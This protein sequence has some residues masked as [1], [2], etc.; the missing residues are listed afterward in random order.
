MVLI[1]RAH[2]FHAGRI[3]MHALYRRRSQL[4]DRL[5]EDLVEMSL[6]PYL[7]LRK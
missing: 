5:L 3:Y 6:S 7:R 2:A 1:R 4:D